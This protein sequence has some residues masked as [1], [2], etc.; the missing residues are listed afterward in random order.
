MANQNTNYT[1]EELNAMKIMAMM[2][3]KDI[4]ELMSENSETLESD[5][6]NIEIEDKKTKKT[7]KVKAT[8]EP[9]KKTNIIEL[10][11]EF[12]NLKS[13]ITINVVFGGHD[14]HYKEQFWN[15]PVR[16]VKYNVEL[17]T[18]PKIAKDVA[19]K[20]N[21]TNKEAE[22]QKAY[23]GITRYYK[24]ITYENVVSNAREIGYI[25]IVKTSDGKIKGRHQIDKILLKKININFDKLQKTLQRVVLEIVGRQKNE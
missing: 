3:G 10:R 5:E 17:I 24:V 13:N 6:I 23:N 15:I 4:N 25:K 19:I 7:R 14:I 18:N 12:S 22:A 20:M 1:K 11:P 16:E 2:Q 9:I 21:A 8:S